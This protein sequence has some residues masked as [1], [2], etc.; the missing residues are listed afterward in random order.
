[1][2]PKLAVIIPTR[3]RPDKLNE[4]LDALAKAQKFFEFPVYVCDSSPDADIKDEVAG[5]C[6]DF[7]FVKLYSHEGKNLAASK[8]FCANIADEPLLINVDD[9]VNVEPQAIQALYQRYISTPGWAVVCGAVFWITNWAGPFV[10]RPTGYGRPPSEGE[11]PSFLLGAFF[12][13]PKALAEF[14]PWNERFSSA[15]DI[16]MGALWRSYNIPLIYEPEARAV[17]NREAP[18]YGLEFV[19]GRIYVNLFDA[20]IA[21]RN[22]PRAAMYEFLGFASGVKR[23]STSLATAKDFVKAWYR[24]HV[25]FVRD[26]KYL[27]ALVG[28]QPPPVRAEIEAYPE[29]ASLGAP[30]GKV[31]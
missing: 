12:L 7:P 20:L 28:K 14:L 8:N 17:H 22:L 15:Q 4:C 31:G 16:F 6:N 26:W 2:D 30:V 25:Y 13:Y 18:E 11:E 24:G 29:P 19:D 27:N 3:S 9:D 10:L 21:N 5:V 23:Y 1:M